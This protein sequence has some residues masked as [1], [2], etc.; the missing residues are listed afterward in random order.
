MSTSCLEGIS[1]HIC[2]LLLSDG[3]GFM[4]GEINFS[5]ISFLEIIG[6]E[7]II[8]ALLDIHGHYGWTLLHAVVELDQNF[9]DYSFTSI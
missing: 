4:K 3:L 2:V 5:L 8:F 7:F 1:D 6:D 9:K